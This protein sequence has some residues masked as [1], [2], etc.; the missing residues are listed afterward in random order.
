MTR[1]ELHASRR[2]GQRAHLVVNSAVKKVVPIKLFREVYATDMVP[3]LSFV[4]IMD[5]PTKL[6][7]EESV[8]VMVPRLRKGFVD[9]K[10]APIKLSKEEFVKGMVLR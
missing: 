4:A 3:R 9:M 10:D 8:K 1:E 2:V 7:K 5:A 6:R